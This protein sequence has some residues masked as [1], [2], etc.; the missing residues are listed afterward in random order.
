V[1]WRV[2]PDEELVGLGTRAGRRAVQGANLHYPR[3]RCH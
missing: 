3:P 2:E 1:R